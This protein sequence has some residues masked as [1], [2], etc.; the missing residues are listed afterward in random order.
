[1]IERIRDYIANCPYLD[2]FAAIN[3]D[4]L[5]DK[6]KT[7]SINESSGYNPV[8]SE[9]VTGN[10][11]MQFIFNFDAKFH[12]NSEKQNNIDNSIFFENF[13]NWLEENNNNGVYPDI[14]NIYPL[15]ISAITNAFIFA[16]NSDE[17]IY[18]IS[19]KFTY[20]KEKE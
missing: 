20:W 13:R 2:E 11:E 16:T 7:Y 9:D 18:R 6:V 10:K 14:E 19:C 8:V 4:Y 1:M 3:I 17:A 5:V 15:S 12:W